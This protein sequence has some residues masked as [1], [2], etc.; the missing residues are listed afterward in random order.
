MYNLRRMNKVERLIDYLEDNQ[1]DVIDFEL[2]IDEKLIKLKKKLKK[3]LLKE[4]K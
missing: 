4:L 2:D 3:E 1:N